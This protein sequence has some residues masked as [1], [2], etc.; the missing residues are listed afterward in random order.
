MNSVRIPIE[1]LSH[2]GG[3]IQPPEMMSEGAAG[4][5]LRAAVESELVLA[6]GDIAAVPTGFKIAV[7]EGFE[8]QIRPRSGLALK[9]G[10]MLPN[11]PG[12]IDSDYRGEVKVILGNWGREA[13]TIRRGDRI[14]QMVITPVYHVQWEPVENVP[15]TTRGE[16]GFG[17][18][19]V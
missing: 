13:F 4:M 2:A 12:T 7:P 18:T 15:D 5:D 6:P 3:D 14:A 8:A 10:I 11:S 17:S 1:M 19:G 9:H 16:G